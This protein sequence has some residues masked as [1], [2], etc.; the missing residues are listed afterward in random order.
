M[1]C[2]T[3]SFIE[4]YIGTGTQNTH[5]YGG[6]ELQIMALRSSLYEGADVDHFNIYVGLKHSQTIKAYGTCNNCIF[7]EFYGIR[8]GPQP[9]FSISFPIHRISLLIW[10]SCLF[11]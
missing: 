11:C 9:S 5:T 1:D 7:P 10:A 2:A 6:G 4:R 3:T 8:G